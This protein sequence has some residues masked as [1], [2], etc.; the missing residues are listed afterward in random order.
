ML[1]WCSV[2]ALLT[3]IF[4]WSDIDIDD[5]AYKAGPILQLCIK[6]VAQPLDYTRFNTQNSWCSV[7]ALLTLC[8]HS[9]FGVATTTLTIL[10]IKVANTSIIGKS[11]SIA[12]GL[13]KMEHPKSLPL[14]WSSYLGVAPLTLTILPR[15][16][17]NAQI[18]GKHCGT[19]LGLYKMQHLKLLTLCWR[20][21]SVW[22]C[23]HVALS[24]AH[25]G[26]QY[27]DYG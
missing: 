1:C 21:F 12:L 9:F 15:K 4:R 17:A 14:W 16:E 11:R 3:H 25:K 22:G 26:C 20:S 18:M 13:Y 24:F 6:A 2:D 10:P 7:N 5:I 23:D 27:V 8:W 19:A